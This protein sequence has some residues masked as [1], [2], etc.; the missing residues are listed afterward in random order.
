MLIFIGL[1][2]TIIM[3]AAVLGVLLL[4]QR[5]PET[6]RPFRVPLYPLPPLLFVGLAIW[7]IISTIQFKWQASIG[8]LAIVL[9][10]WALRPI[11]ARAPDSP[12][13]AQKKS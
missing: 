9:V 7:M 6:E 8:S 13:P 10:V 5:E 12:T 1:P 2:T 11:L 3:G 4:R